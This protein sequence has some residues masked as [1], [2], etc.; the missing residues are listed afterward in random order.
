[1]WFKQNLVGL[2]FS[3][4]YVYSVKPKL[5]FFLILFL[6]CILPGCKKKDSKQGQIPNVYVNF[7]IYLNDPSFA[8]LLSVGNS[9]SVTGG[10]K[11][12]IIYRST[13]DS[14]TALERCSSYKPEDMC[15]VEIDSTRIYAVD[16]CS[17]SKFSLVDGTV[18]KGPATLP[19]KTYQTFYDGENSLH[20]Y[21]Y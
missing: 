21:N 5:S 15:A 2:Y 11:G 8:P 16:P 12:I 19:L 18:I 3:K 1:M 13:F 14:F 6:I 9:V 7:Y 17:L 4:F 20:V 10:V